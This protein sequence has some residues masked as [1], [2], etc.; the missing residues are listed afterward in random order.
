MSAYIDRS[1]FLGDDFVFLGDRGLLLFEGF[2][3]LLVLVLHMRE[4][5]ETISHVLEFAGAYRSWKSSR[6]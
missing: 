6:V 2:V 3:L 5:R 4:M 1:Y